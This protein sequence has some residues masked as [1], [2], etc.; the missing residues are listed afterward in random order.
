MMEAKNQEECDSKE[1][2]YAVLLV[3]ISKG[4]YRQ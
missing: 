1:K 4:A 2:Y 3:G